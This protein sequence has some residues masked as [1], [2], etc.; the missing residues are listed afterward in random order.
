MLLKRFAADSDLASDK[1]FVPDCA[2]DSGKSVAIVG[3][4]PAGLATAF[5]L[6]QFGHGCTI[7]DDHDAPGG[8]LRYGVEPEDLPRDVLDAEIAAIES[9]G[10]EFRMNTEIGRDV[11]LANLQRDF[12]AVMLAIGELPD[13]PAAAL[14]V[15]TGERG[16]AIDPKTLQTTTPGVF[17]GGDATGRKR[18]TV[19]AVADGRAAAAAIDRCVRGEAV[20]G[21]PA[22]FTVRIG[23]LQEGEIERFAVEGSDASRVAP[24]GRR[25]MGYVAEEAREEATRCLHCDCR[26]TP[27]CK[28][29]RYAAAY[30]A[31]P[32]RFRGERRTF[33]QHREHAEI[34]YEPG[35]C[36]ACGLCI[37]IAAA[38]GEP[39]G[40]TFINRGMNVR[41]AVPFARPL[42][43]GLQHVAAECAAACPTAALTL[44]DPPGN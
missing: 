37:Q 32:T 33:E 24:V 22:P 30:D 42:T 38:A 7:F 10:V 14:G 12:D 34:I 26:E 35:K 15:A 31:K 5:Y 3:A 11:T 18:L 28:L 1:P 43:E 44:K 39:L 40:L 29:R 21:E 2:A 9:L 27:G 8:M 13:D 16:V 25:A 4:G 17:S 20:G 41:V 23:R 6:R 36:I 19:R